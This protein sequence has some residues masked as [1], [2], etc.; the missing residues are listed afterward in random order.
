MPINQKYLSFGHKKTY[1]STQTLNKTF[2]F[3]Q[4]I[5]A[6]KYAGHAP[7]LITKIIKNSS[8]GQSYFDLS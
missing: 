7:T 8:D 4:T 5:D 2:G 1:S 6:G 3:T